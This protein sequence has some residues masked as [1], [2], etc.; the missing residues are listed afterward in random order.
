MTVEKYFHI[1]NNLL[2]HHWTVVDNQ[3]KCE[4]FSTIGGQISGRSTLL[5]ESY[6][7]FSEEVYVFD[8][9]FVI[10]RYRYQ[11]MKGVEVFRYDNYPQHPGIVPPFHHKHTSKGVLQLE[12]APKLIEIIQEAVLHMY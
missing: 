3:V 4:R 6:I 1:T 12:T 11:Y 7:D 9:K 8:K 10:G 2:E 5:D